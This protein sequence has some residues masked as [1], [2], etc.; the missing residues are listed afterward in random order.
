[1]HRR[2]TIIVGNWTLSLHLNE[3]IIAQNVPRN[4]YLALV[5]I[6]PAAFFFLSTRLLPST[7]VHRARIISPDKWA[8]RGEADK[9]KQGMNREGDGEGIAAEKPGGNLSAKR[10]S[11]IMQLCARRTCAPLRRDSY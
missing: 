11:I 3:K 4:T 5:D 7:L 2:I 1:M 9:E 6:S 10:E 8:H